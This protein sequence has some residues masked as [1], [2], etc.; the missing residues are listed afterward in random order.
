MSLLPR[1]KP[2]L[3]PLARFIRRRPGPSS[4]CLDMREHLD[5]MLKSDA[6]FIENIFFLSVRP[7]RC[8]Q[9]LPQLGYH[10]RRRGREIELQPAHARSIQRWPHAPRER[11][12]SHEIAEISCVGMPEEPMGRAT[13]LPRSRKTANP[14][15]H[16]IRRR[17]FERE[18]RQLLQVSSNAVRPRERIRQE[19]IERTPAHLCFE[20]ALER[21]IK[22]VKR[23]EIHCPDALIHRTLQTSSHEIGSLSLTVQGVR[24]LL[25]G[26][27]ERTWQIHSH[28]LG[29]SNPRTKEKSNS[30]RA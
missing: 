26:Q 12:P 14:C 13:V 8:V 24:G 19:S 28:I 2:S 23:R 30:K 17:F 7:G 16:G 10:D 27:R 29:A 20:P 6:G 15:N 21:F 25:E 22:G 11:L 5:R 9:G 4:T 1:P 18:H 3:V